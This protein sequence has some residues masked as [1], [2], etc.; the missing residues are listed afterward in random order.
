MNSDFTNR[1]NTGL[2]GLPLLFPDANTLPEGSYNRR[3][4]EDVAPPFFV[5]GRAQLAPTFQWGTRI[6]TPPPNLAYPAFLNTNPTQDVSISLTKIVGRHTMKAG[7]HSNHSL[8]QQNLNQRNALPFQGDLSFANDSNNPL[9]TGFGFANAA[10]GV[11]TSYTQQSSFVEGKFVYNQIEGYAQDNWKASNKL[12]LDYGLRFTHQVPQYD[13]NGQ[14]SNFF[15][16]RYNRSSAP[17]QYLPGCPG[18]VFPCETTRQAMNPLTGSLMGP[19]TAALIGQI[20]PGTGSPTNGIVRAGDGISK[21]NY[22]WPALTVAPRFGAAYDVSGRQAMVLRGGVGLFFDRP[23]GDSIYYQSQNPPTSTNQTVRNGLLQTLGTG[24]VAAS[25]GVPTLIN[26]RYDNPKLPSSLQWNAGVQMTLPWSSSLD[27][28]YVGQRSSH[29]LNAFQSLTAV[30]INAIDFGAAFLPQNQDPTRSAAVAAVAGSG[31]YVQEL[32]RPIRGY[33]NI[34]QQWQEFERTYHSMQFSATRRFRSGVSFGGNYT[35]SLSDNGTTGVPLRLQHSADGSFSVR[36]DQAVF[37]ELMKNQGLQRHIVKANFIWDLPDWQTTGSRRIA[38]AI[39]N[40]WQLSGIFT[41]GSG[42]RYDI[43]YQYQNNGAN[44][45]LTGSPDYAARVVIT[46]DPGNGCGDDR[47]RQF[48]TAAFSG[49]LPSSLGL[50]SGRNYMVGCPD[51]TTDLAIARNFRMGGARSAQIRIE[52]YNAFN[53]VVYNA[54]QTQLQLVSPS[55]QTIRNSQFLADGSVDP[56]R[57]KTT[58]AGFGAVTGAQP[59][60]TIQAQLR[61][62]F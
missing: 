35:L 30:N 33:A 58:S 25:S 37:N 15:L 50:E 54:R 36:E 28:A 34:D 38:A 39:V 52:M 48:N 31:A 57:L 23:D 22:E 17:A 2:Q 6:G 59:L 5:N 8:K 12:T 27:V 44:V 19:G 49:P 20:V 29:V 26:Y 7:F 18:G 46:G 41:G 11:Y 40:D 10:L 16:D 32:L 24:A 61:F 13:A 47:F 62:S 9:D 3:V 56:N 45:N 4:M 1:S 42:A 43:T 55:N 14:A 60:R 51:K 21:Y 53:V